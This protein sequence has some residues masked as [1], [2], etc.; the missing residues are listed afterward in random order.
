MPQHTSPFARRRGS[1]SPRAL[2]PTLPWLIL[3]LLASLSVGLTAGAAQNEDETATAPDQPAAE[4]PSLTVEQITDVP[5]HGDLRVLV[6]NIQRGANNFDQGAEKALAVIRAVQPDVC[7]LQESYDIDGDRPTLGRWMAS[8]L[9]WNAHQAESPHLCVLTPYDIEETFFHEA[10]HAVG[11]RLRDAEGR[12]LIAYSIWIDY[13]AYTPYH[14]RDEPDVTDESLLLNETERSGRLK[15]AQAILAHLQDEEHCNAEIPLLVGGD[16]NCP[17]H[18]DWTEDTA[19]VYRF[20][21]ALDLPV[22]LAMQEAGL[23]DAFRAVHPEPVQAPGITWTPLF[24]GSEEE[25]GTAD[26]IDRLYLHSQAGAGMLTPIA[27][28]TLPTVWED[29]AIPQA[30]RTFPSDHGAVVIDFI[31]RTE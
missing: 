5:R 18:L 17:S 23:V 31:W 7:L 20:R 22:S 3:A 26:R 13:R 1:R 14:L 25:P 29:A 2:R 28:H 19:K 4:V 11:A 15:Q 12:E 8:E 27:A 16:W 10:W 21:R 9:G 30:K 6:W 24:R